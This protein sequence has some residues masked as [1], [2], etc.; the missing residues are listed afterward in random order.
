[1]RFK[2]DGIRMKQGITTLLK[3]NHITVD[4]GANRFAVR[5]DERQLYVDL[6]LALRDSRDD[7]GKKG[8]D[9]GSEWFHGLGDKRFVFQ[10][11]VTLE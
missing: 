8:E 11:E 7:A 10:R 9:D 4:N 1:M 5:I 3:I 2:D 6:H